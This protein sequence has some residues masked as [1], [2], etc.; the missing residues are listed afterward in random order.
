MVSKRYK[1]INERW[2]LL[3]I[4]LGAN[5]RQASFLR[6]PKMG[7]TYKNHRFKLWVTP[8]SQYS[9]PITWLR[10]NLLNSKQVILQMAPESFFSR[11][12]ER[13]GSQDIKTGN[14]EFNELLK[15]K[16]NIREEEVWIL[17]DSSI[18]QQILNLKEPKKFNMKIKKG[19][20]TY[21]ERGISKDP[22]RIKTNLDIML[23]IIKKVE[24]RYSWLSRT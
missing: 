3:A 4:Q 12:S 18:Q 20:A 6:L 9:P 8:G 10:I 16:G 19:F 23:D 24:E 17:L 7:G 13:L 14:P 21:W 22:E 1:E 15:I 2:Q 11:I 5:F